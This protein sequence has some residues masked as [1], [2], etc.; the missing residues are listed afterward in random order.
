MGA[1]S[2]L[3]DLIGK[4]LQYLETQGQPKGSPNIKTASNFLAFTIMILSNRGGYLLIVRQDR[5][6]LMSLVSIPP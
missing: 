6:G 1:C 5:V 3:I 2:L 4:L